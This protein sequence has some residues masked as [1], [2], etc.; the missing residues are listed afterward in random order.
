MFIAWCVAYSLITVR[1]CRYAWSNYIRMEEVVLAMIQ[2][3]ST[4][5]MSGYVEEVM[6]ILKESIQVSGGEMVEIGDYWVTKYS[7]RASVLRD[8]KQRLAR[9]GDGMSEQ[10]YAL[11]EKT[12]TSG[13]PN[14]KFEMIP[15][16]HSE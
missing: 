12:S 10:I 2:I 13:V 5:S 15:D 7:K 3:E 8:I 14:I 6:V 16:R 1:G 9:F 4:R 11:V